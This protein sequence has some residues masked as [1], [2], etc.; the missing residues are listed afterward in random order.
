MFFLLYTCIIIILYHLS[1]YHHFL[2]YSIA[3]YYVYHA[4]VFSAFPLIMP[5]GGHSAHMLQFMLLKSLSTTYFAR[6]VGNICPRQVIIH[7]HIFACWP[8]KDGSAGECKSS[9]SG[10]P[11][12]QIRSRIHSA[13]AGELHQNS[14][15]MENDSMLLRSPSSL[16]SPP[17]S[18]P[19]PFFIPGILQICF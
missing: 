7:R 12:I 14:K 2:L 11:T 10:P 3:S 16:L 8:F 19:W 13:R 4:S 6:L 9:F 5:C 1:C 15:K 18:K 17:R